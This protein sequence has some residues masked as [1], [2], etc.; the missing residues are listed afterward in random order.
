MRQGERPAGEGRDP[1]SQGEALSADLL[2]SGIE[3]VHGNGARG[4]SGGVCVV[5]GVCA[6]CASERGVC[7]AGGRES[8]AQGKPFWGVW[9]GREIAS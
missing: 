4:G 2:G 7:V 3:A 1:G 6:V 5:C 8:V 9:V